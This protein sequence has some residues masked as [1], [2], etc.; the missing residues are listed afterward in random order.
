ML[1]KLALLVAASLVTIQ[2]VVAF[3]IV[4]PPAEQR[5]FIEFLNKDDNLHISFMV[6]EG[7]NSDI[8]FWISDPNGLLVEDA[9]RS[10]SETINHVVKVKGRFE[11]CFSNSFSTVTDKSL[12]FNVIVIEPLK[13][14]STHKSDPLA[15][16]IRELT[17]G[18]ME[19]SNE[20]EYT[21]ARERTHRN[22]AESTNSRV[23]WWSL[24]QSGILFLV[25]A[26]Q[27]TYLK[28]F[29]EVKRVV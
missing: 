23:M 25:C 12:T 7:G 1:R 9:K 19:I 13:E 29:F 16:E 26:F 24:F 11:F 18:V 3:S 5:C 28:R 22:T 8:D 14:D 10:A 20:L 6:G 2:T 21:L 17:A 4:V 15:N 27:I